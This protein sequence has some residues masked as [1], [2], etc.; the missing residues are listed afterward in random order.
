MK[1][2]V[3]IPTKNAGPLFQKVLDGVLGQ[4]APW[5]FEV[6]VIDSGSSDG[7]L[8][9]VRA[10]PAVRL[11]EIPPAEFGHGRTR[12]RAIAEA[13]GEFCALLT[14]DALPENSAWLRTLVAAVEQD[15]RIAGAFGR[16]LPYPE[17]SP[18]TRRDLINHFTGFLSL[19]LVVSRDMDP[20]RFATDT[21]WRQ[22]LHFYSDN[23]SC[24]RRSVWTQIP[25]PDVDFAED[26][27][28]ALHAIEAGWHKAYAHDAV[29]YHSHDYG[30]FE[31]LQRAFD[32]ALSFRTLFG[33]R[34]GA[35]SLPGALAISW[36]LIRT[37]WAWARANKVPLG[38]TLH[39]L[40]ENVALIIGHSL[41]ARGDSLPLAVREWL[42]RDKRLFRAMVDRSAASAETAGP[43]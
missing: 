7:T 29:V 10:R 12:N 36:R 32:E 15:D 4:E 21:G 16:H 26:Q 14:H 13:R 2:S 35:R 41:G 19:P 28:W 18:F 43:A 11:I 34:L 22:V 3:I 9:I 24:L 33:Y 23:N 39:R 27:I 5:P 38:A 40:A 6:I 25:Y 1:A 37:D 17:A 8:D 31:R 42:S 30:V 20:D